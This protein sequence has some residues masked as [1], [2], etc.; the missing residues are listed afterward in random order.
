M[1]LDGEKPALIVYKQSLNHKDI[2]IR[3]NRPCLHC[4]HA[5]QDNEI[6]LAA[7]TVN[8][9]RYQKLKQ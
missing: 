9:F 4:S 2:L 6:F 1:R 8:S 7:R 5:A 3:Y